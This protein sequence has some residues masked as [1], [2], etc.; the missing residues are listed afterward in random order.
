MIPLEGMTVGRMDSGRFSQERISLSHAMS[1][2]FRSM[3]RDA[4]ETSVTWDFPPERFQMIQE[5][6]QPIA[7]LPRSISFCRP[8]TLSM[9]HRA[10]VAEKYA[11]IGRPVFSLIA[12][13]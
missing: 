6:M 8:G 12:C 9:I 4:W 10:F 3:V 2:M 13:S 7:M 1:W 11:S 5:S